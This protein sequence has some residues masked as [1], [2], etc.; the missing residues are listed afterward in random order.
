MYFS[1]YISFTSYKTFVPYV[2]HVLTTVD[3]NALVIN[4]RSCHLSVLISL[5]G[6]APTASWYLNTYREHR[7]IFRIMKTYNTRHVN[8][9]AITHRYVMCIFLEISH[10]Q[11]N[12]NE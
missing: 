3:L 6:H 2:R 5:I 4:S 9:A 10:D 11:F 8:L 7:V 1:L 12:N